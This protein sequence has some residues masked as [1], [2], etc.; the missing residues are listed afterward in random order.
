MKN[1]FVLFTLPLVL[2]SFTILQKS[3]LDYKIN[4]DFTLKIKGTSNL[5]DW[6]S[7]AETVT[8]TAKVSFD[9]SGMLEVEECLVTI[10]VK[11]IKSTKGSIM[12][13]KTWNALKADEYANIKYQLIDFG[14]L[15]KST[16]GFTTNTTGNLTIAGTTKKINLTVKGKELDN[17]S[18]EITG[19]KAMKM[20]DFNVEPP[21]ALLGAL[22]TGDDVTIEFRI[23][24]SQH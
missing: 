21:T 7:S 19:S 5:H 23:V 12:D 13:K 22:T 15:V 17:G 4:T 14:N 24:L 10:P 9:D 18:I 2:F 8:G 11:S 20:T 1:L 16:N 3:V 6:E